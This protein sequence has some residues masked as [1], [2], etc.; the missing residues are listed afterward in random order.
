[1]KE[2]QFEYHLQVALFIFLAISTIGCLSNTDFDSSVL[3][4]FKKCKGH[5]E[6]IIDFAS[7]FDFKWDTV[8]YFSGKYS[9]EEVNKELGFNLKKYTDVGSRIIFVLDGRDVY[10]KEWFPY[11]ESQSS[12]DNVFILTD[13]EKFKISR[14]NAKFKIKK[15][16]NR[17]FIENP[18]VE[19]SQSE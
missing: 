7:T 16:N 8:Y 9:L 6:C 14:N 17:F 12:N 3:R 18:P 2:T 5:K 1:M 10:V 15:I 19:R 11:P 13:L 4:E